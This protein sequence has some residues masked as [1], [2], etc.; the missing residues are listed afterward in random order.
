MCIDEIMVKRELWKT[1]KMSVVILLVTVLALF[2]GSVY[3]LHNLL[4]QH[5]HPIQ[6]ATHGALRSV[7]QERETLTYNNSSK[8]PSIGL[9]DIFRIAEYGAVVHISPNPQSEDVLTLYEHAF[10]V[11]V[12]DGAGWVQI[13]HPKHVQGWVQEI[14]LTKI[15]SVTLNGG[16][17]N[18]A[19]VNNR[20]FKVG[21][22]TLGS[23]LG[24]HPDEATLSFRPADA[25]APTSVKID[26]G[27]WQDQSFIGARGLGALVGGGFHAEVVPVSSGAFFS[28]PRAALVAN[29]K[30][31][32]LNA[33][34]LAF[35]G[36]R[37]ALMRGDVV[38]ADHLSK[39]W[40][41]SAEGQFEYVADLALSFTSP[42]FEPTSD[43]PPQVVA[44]GAHSQPMNELFRTSTAKARFAAKFTALHRQN[45]VSRRRLQVKVAPVPGVP[46]SK[47]KAKPKP[48]ATPDLVRQEVVS[49]KDLQH[50]SFLDME[51]GLATS[52]FLDWD[53]LTVYSRDWFVD[54]KE[55]ILTGHFSSSTVGETQA[56]ALDVHLKVTRPHDPTRKEHP[57]VKYSS[58]GGRPGAAVQNRLTSVGPSPNLVVPHTVMCITM[59]CDGGHTGNDG[60]DGR[61]ADVNNGEVMECTGGQA[62]VYVAVE[63][64]EFDEEVDVSQTNSHTYNTDKMASLEASCWRRVGTYSDQPRSEVLRR[65]R[66]K[67]G[68]KRTAAKLHLHHEE[69]S[70]GDQSDSEFSRALVTDTFNMGR[71]LLLASSDKYISNLQGIW[72]DGPR[73]A[74]AGD[75][76][77]NIN[78]QMMHWAP[79]ALGFGQ[80]FVKPLLAWS[81][82]LRKAGARTAKEQYKCRGWV[83]H[84][85]LDE[86]FDTGTAGDYHWA[87]CV[88]C[89]A[90]AS[91]SLWEY[92]TYL[93]MD[94]E[95]GH[96]DLLRNE[97]L[98]ALAGAIDFFMDYFVEDGEGKLHTGPTTS[99]ENSYL[100]KNPAAAAAA[101]GASMEAQHAPVETLHPPDGPNVDYRSK[102]E[103]GASIQKNSAKPKPAE[104]LFAQLAMSPAIDMSILRQVL[105]A[106]A[107]TIEELTTHAPR[108]NLQPQELYKEHLDRLSRFADAVGRLPNGALPLVNEKSGTV[109]EYFAHFDSSGRNIVRA[110][111]QSRVTATYAAP[112]V[113]ESADKGHRHFSGM[114][115]LYPNTF[116]PRLSRGGASQ[117]A[118]FAAAKATLDNKRKDGGGHAGW[119]AAWETALRARL[120][121]GEE[122]WDSLV[123]F[124]AH[125][126]THRLL[127]LHPKLCVSTTTD[128]KTCFRDPQ[129]NSKESRDTMV[130]SLRHARVPST[131]PATG[132][133]RGLSTG[134]GGLFQIDGNMG[135]VA[136]MVEMLV[137][138]HVSGRIGLLPAIPQEWIPSSC[139]GPP[140]SV[141]GLVARGDIEIVKMAWNRE[142]S[143]TQAPPSSHFQTC[144]RFEEVRLNFRS[145]HAW[146]KFRHNPVFRRFDFQYGSGDSEGSE[147]EAEKGSSVVIETKNGRGLRMVST[148]ACASAATLDGKGLTLT[149]TSYPCSVHLKEK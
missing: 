38:G 8:G 129:L 27:S 48:K 39:A 32:G 143:C 104:F 113:D 75:Y 65:Q 43:H 148:D 41:T 134:D 133:R 100:I 86:Y 123:R 147:S 131:K 33:S 119:S 71:Y 49:N 44:Q 10:V 72:A 52:Q 141:E 17:C 99:P 93:P 140:F 120:G 7:A 81:K 55:G 125:Y 79:A 122:A 145:H 60:E 94:D 92:T 35:V 45:K 34:H 18:R 58:R 13:T 102:E 26:S 95:H 21:Q 103:S 77:L 132:G 64:E 25:Q 19:E 118:L 85:F 110:S 68:G 69:K 5:S 42:A 115:F 67:F 135:V 76:H 127:G 6:D 30:G 59:L 121:N 138:S 40:H 90:W 130:H 97:A 80:S 62:R 84:G 88:T 139:D 46:K 112:L 96:G 31:D 28:I 101:A 22:W 116:A 98:E 56:G 128:C 82:R 106:Y 109:M 3:I 12:P 70:G 105:L 146:H 149:I 74:W 61:S 78:F 53:F 50:V 4:P 16:R 108:S 142:C 89:G 73:S 47:T 124:M 136:A 54:A 36:M 107:Y 29:R 51:S 66:S 15:S 1:S 144:L 24:R 111:A 9:S 117:M 57:V 83:A 11:G 63:K 14:S 20:P 91:L 137:Q 2:L 114:H 87:L 23:C 126:T 37:E